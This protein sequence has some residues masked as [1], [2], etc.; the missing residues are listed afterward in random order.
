MERTQA[1]RRRQAKGAFRFSAGHK[2]ASVLLCMTIRA[3]IV[4]ISRPSRARLRDCFDD[5]NGKEGR[6]AIC[7]EPNLPISEN[8]SVLKRME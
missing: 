3:P 2:E 8:G 6:V 4:E 7:A 1:K 5:R